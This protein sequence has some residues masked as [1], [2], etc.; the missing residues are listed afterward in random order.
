M[1]ELLVFEPPTDFVLPMN[2]LP[3]LYY[4]EGKVDAMPPN[5]GASLLKRGF[6]HVSN[7]RRGLIQANGPMRR[8]K[9]AGKKE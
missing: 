3:E 4:Y 5:D 6:Q 2:A 9:Y 7:F 1:L 8:Q